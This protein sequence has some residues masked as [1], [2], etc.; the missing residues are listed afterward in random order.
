MGYNNPNSKYIYYLDNNKDF[1]EFFNKKDRNNIKSYFH[2][3]DSIK[4]KH[5]TIIRKL[6]NE[7]KNNI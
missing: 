1:Y 4:Y 5:I 7:I 3:K 2:K 6:K